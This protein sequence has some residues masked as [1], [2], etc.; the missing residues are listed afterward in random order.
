MPAPPSP[1]AL[2]GPAP[3]AQLRG[4]ALVQRLDESPAL[5]R[6]RLELL[7]VDG[8]GAPVSRPQ[9]RSPGASTTLI[10]LADLISSI[11]TVGVLN[12]ILVEEVDQPGAVPVRWI[13]TGER[14]AMSVRRGLVAAPDNPH[15]A[16]IPAVVCPG[17][18]TEEER[19][20]W[21]LIENL[22]REDLQP[23]ELGAALLFERSAVLAGQLT[24]AGVAVPEQVFA[25]PDPVA[26]Y[27]LLERVRRPHPKVGAPWEVVL[28][29]LGLQLS[30]RKARAVVAALCTLP[31][32][33]SADLDAHKVALHTRV[34]LLRVG[35]GHDDVAAELWAEV[36]RLGRPD[37]LA[38]A[39]RAHRAGITA[40][41]AAAAAAEVQRAEANAA[42]A[43]S[44][45]RPES[46]TDPAPA[47]VT[48]QVTDQVTD[49][50]AA[51]AADADTDA[52]DE[53]ARGP[54][55]A[56]EEEGNP[57]PGAVAAPARE[58]V[59]QPVAQPAAAAEPVP[60]AVVDAALGGLRDLA[61]HLAVGRRLSRYDSGSVRL[62]ISQ[63]QHHLASRGGGRTEEPTD[64]ITDEIS[65]RKPVA[66]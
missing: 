25:E 22:A 11:A 49:P 27:R 10:G 52:V 62:L 61:R 63:V 4:D 29:R 53:P 56:G 12:P 18:L 35:T 47:S 39:V 16:A 41:S 17:P 31:R 65:A 37:L 15:F 45:R 26:R 60:A 2:A 46:T 9:G 28:R 66:A 14:R 20:T 55:P 24:A 58:P 54:G 48:D 6:R 38:A 23:G 8:P 59:S 57:R 7:P 34:E 1:T 43:H 30:P 40:P 13:V 21:Q 42:R 44:L 33:M 32:E 3:A 64:E 50:A 5:R 19:R 36:K 51:V